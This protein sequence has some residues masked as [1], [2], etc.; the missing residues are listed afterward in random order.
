MMRCEGLEGHS[1][2]DDA[3]RLGLVDAQV[4][5]LEMAQTESMLDP[6]RLDGREMVY[7]VR[8]EGEAGMKHV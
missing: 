5:A 7:H 3:L 2:S 8:P 1:A 4:E 6:Q